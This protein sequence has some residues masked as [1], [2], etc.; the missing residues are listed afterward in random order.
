MTLEAF[1]TDNG[2]VIEFDTGSG[3]RLL[4]S[5]G[6]A[7][8]LAHSTIEGLSEEVATHGDAIVVASRVAPPSRRHLKSYLNNLDKTEARLSDAGT[9]YA[10]ELS[11]LVA[12][13]RGRGID[14]DKV[15]PSIL[16][17]VLDSIRRVVDNN[18]R[19][20]S[21]VARHRQ[22]A[23]QAPSRLVLPLGATVRLVKDWSHPEYYS[24]SP[25]AAGA[26]MPRPVAGSIGVV[27][28][29]LQGDYEASVC[30]TFPDEIQ[31]SDGERFRRLEDYLGLSRSVLVDD[32]EVLSYALDLEGQVSLESEIVPTHRE[33]YDLDDDDVSC[34]MIL[35]SMDRFVV[36]HQGSDPFDDGVHF[37]NDLGDLENIEELPVR[38]GDMTT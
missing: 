7:L 32:V 30:V 10:S 20:V 26:R 36:F 34:V 16:T 12:E 31:S 35:R 3:Y 25:M 37:I 11:G 38:S 8:T 13:L 33:V 22:L 5:E 4:S 15:G 2:L 28:G 24:L 17:D 23:M 19:H 29:N 6:Q 9:R 18:P 14:P 21:E 27:T 1:N